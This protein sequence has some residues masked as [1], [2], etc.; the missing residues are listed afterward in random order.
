MFRRA[1]DDLRI[2]RALGCDEDSTDLDSL[3][4]REK[5]CTL[6]R[7][8]LAQRLCNRRVSDNCLLR[9]ADCS[10]IKAGSRQDIPH[11]FRDIGTPFDKNRHVTRPDPKGWLSG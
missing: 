6:F 4:R 9:C 5:P 2:K 3:F 8:F 7:E 10:V 11:R 1:T